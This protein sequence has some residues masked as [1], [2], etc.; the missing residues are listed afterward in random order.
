MSLLSPTDGAGRQGRR[1]VRHDAGW[2]RPP[3][4]PD[5]L[6]CWQRPPPL[7]R[8]QRGRVVGVV[9]AG[10]GLIPATASSVGL[11]LAAGSEVG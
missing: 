1:R 5:D 6:P 11:D 4:P 7:G 8:I 9:R 2:W 3:P 10:G